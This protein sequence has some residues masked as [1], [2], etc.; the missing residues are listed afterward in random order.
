MIF[1]IKTNACLFS[2][3][4]LLTASF[5]VMFNATKISGICHQKMR[6]SCS[7]K[8]FVID[9]KSHNTQVASISR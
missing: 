3:I 4:I 9:S 8:T 1:K 5:L 6:Q 2:A 7:E